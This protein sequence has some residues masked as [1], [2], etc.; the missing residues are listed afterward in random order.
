MGIMSRDYAAIAGRTRPHGTR[1]R[2]MRIVAD[3][4]WDAL[5]KAGVS[6]IGFYLDQPGQPDDRRL[7]LGPHR[8]KPACSPIGLHGVCGKALLTGQIQIVRDVNEL[9]PSYIACDPRARSEIVIPLIDPQG[10]SMSDSMP[11]AWG[12]L[13]AEGLMRVLRAAGLAG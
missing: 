5:C 4:L 12:V 1:E 6:W 2:R 7:I 13:D 3:Q 11:R 10:S 8:D 9:G